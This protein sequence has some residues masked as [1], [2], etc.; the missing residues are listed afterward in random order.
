MSKTD[1]VMANSR[2]YD[3]KAYNLPYTKMNYV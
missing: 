1:L 3:I 2:I